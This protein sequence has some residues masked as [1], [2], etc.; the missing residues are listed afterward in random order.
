VAATSAALKRT[1]TD[2]ATELLVRFYPE[3]EDLFSRREKP[4]PVAKP[5]EL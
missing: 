3:A 2:A 1:L 5:A 4:S